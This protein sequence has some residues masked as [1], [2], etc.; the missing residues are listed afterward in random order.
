MVFPQLIIGTFVNRFTKASKDIDY[1]FRWI[2]CDYSRARMFGWAF[3]RAPNWGALLEAILAWCDIS[4]VG[5]EYIRSVCLLV[6]A[7]LL[8]IVDWVVYCIEVFWVYAKIP[9]VKM[10][11]DR[12]KRVRANMAARIVQKQSVHLRCRSSTGKFRK[13]YTLFLNI[14]R[15]W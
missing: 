5:K 7:G 8:S 1:C 3:E 10:K 4:Q 12:I 15:Q 13:V 14:Y 2:S 6:I 9:L 11:K